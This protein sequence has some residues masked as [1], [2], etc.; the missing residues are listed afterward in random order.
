MG[1]NL[2]LPG[3]K[4]GGA[5]RRKFFLITGWSSI[6][7]FLG[8]SGVAFAK[9]FY[10]GVLYEPQTTF[11]AGKPEDFVAPTKEGDVVIDERFK[12]TQ[13]VWIARGSTGI[14]AMVAVCTHLGCTPNWFPGEQ[15]FKCPCHGS[16]YNLEG[17]VV[18]GPAPLPLYRAMI[19]QAPDGSM[20]VTTGLL[21]IKRPELQY[22][23][24]VLIPRWTDE[25]MKVITKEPYFLTV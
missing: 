21:G 1:E 10:P 4:S 11:N 25:E 2:D 12:K 23:K 14:Y 8:G 3:E 7:L 20:I 6:G 9:F 19:S 24:R 17:E 15:R 13:R 22:P 16:N 18:A 5:S